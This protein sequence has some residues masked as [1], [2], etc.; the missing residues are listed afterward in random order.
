MLETR[1]CR[2]LNIRYPI[3]QAAMAWVTNAEMVAAISSAGG[4]GTLGPNAGATTITKDPHEVGERLR[5]EIKKVRDLTD[6][7]FAVNVLVPG[8]GEEEFSEVT[9]RVAIEEKVP[10]AIVSQGSPTVYTDRLK[11]AGMKVLHVVANP[12][13]ATKAESAGVDAVI[14]SGT[15]GGGHSGFEGLTTFILVPL[16]ADA[17]RI[18]V[19]A[20]G[21]VGDARGLVAA[22]AL[23]AEGVYI[24][25]RF[26]ATKECPVHQNWKEAL[27]R[28]EAT[29]TAAIRH[30]RASAQETK[31]ILTEMRFGSVRILSNERARK[32]LELQ[33]LGRSPDEIMA[34]YYSTP[35]GYEGKA[36]SRSMISV[37]YGDLVHGNVGAGQVVGL[38]NDI[39][40]CRELIERIVKDADK[41]MSRLSRTQR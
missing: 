26:T 32:L 16:I 38:I 1:L 39:P 18:P 37:L 28:S 4:L 24:G 13:H 17:V 5:T 34:S 22:L 20:G 23:G 12:R 15:E 6:K 33:A 25:T 40:T 3:V 29:D 19:I 2:L 36:V 35:P 8:P 31:D 14:T 10:A 21:G 41:I 11:R 27:V 9:A 30:G 7:P